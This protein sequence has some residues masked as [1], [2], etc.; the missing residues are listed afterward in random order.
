MEIVE[1][2]YPW[3]HW[4]ISDFLSAEDFQKVK[5]THENIPVDEHTNIHVNFLN[6]GPV[7]SILDKAMREF[8]KEIGYDM[9]D[10]MVECAM[11]NMLPNIKYNKIHCDALWKKATLVLGVGDTGTGTHI[12]EKKDPAYYVNTTT[13]KPNGGMLFFRKSNVTWHD[14]DSLGLE[15]IR[16]TILIWITTHELQIEHREEYRLSEQDRRA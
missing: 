5:D 13:Y 12:Y 10:H 7:K 6:K 4:M 3:K 11:V 2:S 8:A 1:E 15:D 14:Y 9:T 16:R